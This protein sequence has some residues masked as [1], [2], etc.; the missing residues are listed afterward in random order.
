MKIVFVVPEISKTG[1]M[2]IIFEYA[3]RLTQD[4]Y[5]V[6]IVSPIVPF[7]AFMGQ[8]SLYYLKY[9]IKY[10]LRFLAGK[11]E[12]PEKF[13]KIDF[14]I[15]YIPYPS[16]NFFSEADVYIAT[17]WTSSYL[18]N[19]INCD[20]KFY[21]VQD[22]ETWTGNTKA[23]DESYKLNLQKIVVSTYLKNLLKD[24]FNEDSQ[25]V[26]NGIDFEKFNNE[27]KKDF[28]VRTILFMD[29]S[30][31]NKNTKDAVEIAEK[32]HVEYP[33]I[34]FKCFG[35]DRYTKMPEY[36]EFHKDPTDEEIIKLYRDSDIFLYTS[37]YEGFAL[38]PAEAMACKCAVVGYNTAAL[39]DY[40]VNDETALLCEAGDKEK[41][42][43]NVEKL[44]KDEKCSE[45]ISSAGYKYVKE[46]LN[47]NKSYKAFEEII[48]S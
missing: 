18:V 28:G 3:N 11:I 10:A 20:K 7:N 25:I 2:R 47:W 4:G 5:E 16:K 40:S 32:I 41:L 36:V 1:G 33:E 45:K 19:E 48:L 35:R 24:K 31:E 30:L 44:I 38:P 15:K 42:F 12:K 9:R 8:R 46:K 17:S 27:E 21:F 34:K 6:T 23:V 14:K 39:P 22:Y 43:N 29:H 13:F 26:L 37:L